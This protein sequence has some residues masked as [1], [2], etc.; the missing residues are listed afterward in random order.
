MDASEVPTPSGS[1][2]RRAWQGLAVLLAAMFMALLDSRVVNV[3]LPTMQASLDASASS[4]S[5]VIAGYALALG[6]ALIPAG[7]LGDRAGHKYV[8]LAGVAVFT[9]ASAACGLAQSDLQLVLFRFLQ[10]LGGGLFTPAVTAFIQLMFPGPV[11]GKAFSVMGGVIGVSSA[12]GPVLGGTIIGAFGDTH[13]WRLVFWLNVPIGIAALAGAAL[14]LH[15]DDR[16]NGR[17]GPGSTCSV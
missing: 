6:L 4:L 7:R 14:L 5:W 12:V 3:A 16:P 13:G 8:F 2:A 10:G 15:P 11:R 9:M 1:Q 17:A